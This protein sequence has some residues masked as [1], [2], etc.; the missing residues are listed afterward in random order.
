MGFKRKIKPAGPFRPVRLSVNFKAFRSCD[1]GKTISYEDSSAILKYYHLSPFRN[2][3]STPL[4]LRK[5]WVIL[6][7]KD[8]VGFSPLLVVFVVFF[9]LL[10]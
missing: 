8:D 2:I 4:Y 7:Y 5:K 1:Q 6:F 10:T 3:Q 9:N